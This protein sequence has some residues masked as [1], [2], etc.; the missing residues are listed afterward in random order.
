MTRAEIEALLAK[1]QQSFDSRSASTLAA[2]HIPNGTFYSPAAGHVT[3]REA[4]QKVYDYWLEAFPDMQ[5]TLGSP[6]IEGNRA[7]LFWEFRG[8]LHGQFFGDVKPGT[9]VSFPGSAEYEF[10]S[11]GIVD[12]KHLFDF[13]GALVTA[14]V[15]K[16]KPT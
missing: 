16:V 12:V 7:A 8:T 10:S 3:G 2:D 1:H 6:I 14:G 11:E 5:M 13:T 4:I 9:K 15:L